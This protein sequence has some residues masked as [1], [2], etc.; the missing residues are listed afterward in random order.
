MRG[1]IWTVVAL[2]SGLALLP[3]IL[4]I[5]A[6]DTTG[7]TVLDVVSPLAPVLGVLLFVAAMAV[8]ITMFDA[9]GF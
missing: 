8:V 9:D 7:Q 6:T 4:D 5:S 2:G 3:A 1:T